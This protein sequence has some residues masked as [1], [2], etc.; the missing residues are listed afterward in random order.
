MTIVIAAPWIV[1]LLRH[2]RRSL[3]LAQRRETISQSFVWTTQFNS[4]S[5]VEPSATRFLAYIPHS[6]FHNQRIE[7]ENAIVLAKLLNRTLVLPLARLGSHPLTYK[8]F[9]E[10]LENYGH[11]D[12]ARLSHCR[13]EDTSFNSTVKECR[14]F[15][16]YTHVSWQDIIDLQR[17]MG[18]GVGIV[19]RW[20]FTPRYLQDTLGV[21]DGDTFW[22]KDSSAYHFQFH[23]AL[24]GRKGGGKF[25]TYI[26]IP[27]FAVSSERYRLVHLG[28]L[29]GTS[30][31]SLTSRSNDQLLRKVRAAMRLA[32]ARLDSLAHTVTARMGGTDTYHAI[33]F[34]SGDGIFAERARYTAQVILANVLRHAYGVDIFSRDAFKELGLNTSVQAF[35]RIVLSG[36]LPLRRPKKIFPR[37]LCVRSGRTREG[38]QVSLSTPLFIATDAYNPRTHALLE[39]YRRI[40]PCIAFL[41]DFPDVAEELEE[42]VNPLDGS[43]MA[44][45]FLP[46]L[47]ATI[48]SR[49][50]SFV[51]T[52]ESTFSKYV[53]EVLW[54]LEHNLIVDT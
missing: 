41:S 52:P 31:L 22:L 39:A 34:R 32:N 15:E 42:L 30:R 27:D 19:E 11:S 37:R 24:K 33:H 44:R 25:H 4:L 46:F 35:Q 50:A 51:G 53:K 16:R 26:S 2:A 14:K 10:L 6:G 40:F 38:W 9:D 29:F 36:S 43:P 21:G 20:D 13:H 3:D 17:V 1:N 49:A 45:F 18:L 12:K 23:D 48:L 5:T 47:D 8:P 28:T 7:L 54:P